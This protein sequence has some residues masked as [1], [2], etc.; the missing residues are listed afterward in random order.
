MLDVRDY[1]QFDPNVGMLN[2]EETHEETEIELNE[3]E[4]IFLRGQ[5]KNSVAMSP[6]KIVKN[7]DGSM[8]RAATTQSALARQSLARPPHHAQCA[9]RQAGKHA[10]LCVPGWL[11]S[12]GARELAPTGIGLKTQS[13]HGH[14]TGAKQG[15]RELAYRPSTSPRVA[16]AFA[17]RARA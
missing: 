10:T 11:S 17:C 16:P 5:T 12:H 4:P 8:Q 6:I 13:S 3:N 14:G 9:P 2:V 15:P 7:P 1:P